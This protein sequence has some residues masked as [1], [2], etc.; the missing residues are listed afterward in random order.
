MNM[1]KVLVSLFAGLVGAALLSFSAM[2]ENVEAN[3][4]EDLNENTESASVVYVAEVDGEQYTTLSLAIEN[5]TNKSTITLLD[6]VVLAETVIVPEDKTLTIDLK[7]NSISMTEELKLSTYAIANL[8][9]LTLKDTKGNG[10]VNSRGIYNGY[11]TV[12]T[13]PDA[14][15]TIESGTYN[16]LGTNGGA[17]VF[18]YGTAN[19]NGGKFT[20]IGGYSLNNQSDSSMT[21]EDDVTANNG[22]YCSGATLVING[23]EIEGNRSGCHV[24]YAW[25]SNV[26]INGGEFYNNNSGNSTTMAAGTTEMEINGGTFGIKD[27]R[28]PGNG[29]TWTSCLLDTQNSATMVINDGTF[30]GGFRVQAGTKAI[31]NGG[32][33]NDVYGS[34]YNIY[35]TVEVKGGMFTDDTAKNFATS[36]LAKD[37]ITTDYTNEILAV[38]KK[39]II[40]N[41]SIT[42][43]FVKAD[44]DDKNNDTDRNADIYNINLVADDAKAI[45]R[46]NSADLTFV[47]SQISGTNA[48]EIIDIENDK[49][50][51]NNVEG[52]RYE[53]HFET[54][55]D[56]TNDTNNT[57]T[58]AQ[59]KI[60][61]YGKYSF[62]VDTADTNAVHATEVFDNIVD[63]YIPGGNAANGEGVLN[64]GEGTGPVEIF[65]PTQTLTINVSFPNAVENKVVDYQDMNVLVTGEDIADISIDLGNDNAGEELELNNKNGANYTVTFDGV[66]CVYTIVIENALTANTAYNVTVSGAGY[67]T[68]RYT[69]NTQETNKVLNFWNN[70]KDNAVEVEEKKDSSKKNVTFLAGDI[71]KDSVINIYD[72]SAVVSYF[73]EIELSETNNK[74]Y[75]KYDLNRDGK[76]DSKD[77]AY[78][79][80]SWG[81]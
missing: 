25:N 28:V 4:T 57:I 18:N 72:L 54:K 52:D 80:V 40:D 48:Y 47:L 34:N 6:D 1:K 68:A 36:N 59:V 16:A 2:A 55:T 60:S 73:G 19:I 79:L 17:A 38:V 30:N 58:I 49:I 81:N 63:T 78:V 70:V 37:Y 14:V 53:F 22:I 31:I 45:N 27:G 46:L 77:V 33:F 12:K 21:I 43:E 65:A 39:E 20:S 23:G 69:V 24:L 5:A 41:T 8:G 9:N 13:Y 35:G 10:S 64:I 15:I 32:S 3:T 42:V 67:R 29:N 7:G 51:V 61:G 62:A 75:A 11:D 71:V 66:K 50:A 74:T 56:V 76:I 26:T 44:K